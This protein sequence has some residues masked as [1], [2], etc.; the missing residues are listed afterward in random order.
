MP[1]STNVGTLVIH[2][3]DMSISEKTKYLD[4]YALGKSFAF[5][6]CVENDRHREK[7]LMR[8]IWMK[9]LKKEQ[10]SFRAI[11]WQEEELLVYTKWWSVVIML[12]AHNEAAVYDTA[13][14]FF[15]I[16]DVI[17]KLDN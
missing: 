3:R 12:C 15:S 6:L 7:G 11:D 14:K 8:D 10:T 17:N 16:T 1:R 5:L 9:W 13:L 4:N 2:R